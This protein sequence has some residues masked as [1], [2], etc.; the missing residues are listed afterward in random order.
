MR[1]L[2][3]KKKQLFNSLQSEYLGNHGKPTADN[4]DDLKWK[5]C[6]LV[7]SAFS[8]GSGDPGSIPILYNALCFL[9]CQIWITKYEG[10]PPME[11]KQ[12]NYSIQKVTLWVGHFN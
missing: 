11:Y 7:G 5:G 3:P 6:D 10:D 12:I 9:T 8:S 1:K 2:T 4:V